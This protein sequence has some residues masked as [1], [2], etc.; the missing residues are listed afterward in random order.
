MKKNLS[1]LLFIVLAF[2]LIGCGKDGSVGTIHVTVFNFEQEEVFDGD[3]KFAEDDTLQDLLAEHKEIK[4]KGETS[5]FGFYIV[6]MVGF[7]SLDHENTFWNIKVN[8]E[9]S[10]VGISLIELVD[11]DVI[12]FHL[13]GW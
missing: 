12:E 5:T 7:S 1:F 13:I 11:K 10:L 8:G 4:M 9:D 2:I 6:E 3:I